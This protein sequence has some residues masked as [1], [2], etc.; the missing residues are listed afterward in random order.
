MLLGRAERSWR[1]S[2]N[3]RSSLVMRSM[4]APGCCG[5][6]EDILEVEPDK[7]DPGSKQL[8]SFKSHPYSR[9][10]CETSRVSP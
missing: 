7:G 2:M 8:H 5:V 10:T 1:R 3:S 9:C 6:S 4:M